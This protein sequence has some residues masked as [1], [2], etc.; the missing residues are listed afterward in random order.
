MREEKVI[1]RLLGRAKV[2]EVDA[3]EETK[4]EAAGAKPKAA[5]APK[6]AAKKTSKKA[7]KVS[8]GEKEDKE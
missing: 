4:A 3:A 7:K 2:T 8:S 5:K 6:K 1:D